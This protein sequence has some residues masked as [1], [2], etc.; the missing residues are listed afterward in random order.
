MSV[1]KA[2]RST[3]VDFYRA[4]GYLLL[5]KLYNPFETAKINVWRKEIQSWKSHPV[6]NYLQYYEMNSEKQL[7]PC[8]SEN[9]AA[10]HEDFNRLFRSERLTSML[11]QIWD[12]EVCLFKEKINYKGSGGGGYAPH[13]DA[14][15]YAHIDP[16]ARTFASILVAAEEATPLNGCLE[17]VPG[18]HKRENLPP[19]RSDKT[20][21]DEWSMRQMWKSI[22]LQPGDALLFDSYLAHRSGDNNSPNDRA[23]IYATYNPKGQGGDLHDAYYAHRIKYYPDQAKRQ[24]NVDYSYGAEIY[25]CATPME[26]GHQ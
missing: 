26:T 24:P 21:R 18:S 19:L 13:Y 1:F 8:A 23:T 11:M 3:S 7:V 15:S 25:A 10:H 2:L 16:N 22:P 17:I 5:P 6:K 20:I 9:F 14:V 12:D 4:N